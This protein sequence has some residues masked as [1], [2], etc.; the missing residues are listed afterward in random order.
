MLNI[1]GQLLT[2]NCSEKNRLLRRN[3]TAKASQAS[4]LISKP[5][6]SVGGAGFSLI[7]EMKLNKQDP[8]DK[9]LYNDILV[10]SEF[11]GVIYS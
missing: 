2:R 9:V 8:K 11:L 3:A 1:D 4:E 7:T 6:G 5:K 10:W